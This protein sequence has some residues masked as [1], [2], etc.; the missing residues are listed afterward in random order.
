MPSRTRFLLSTLIAYATAAGLAGCGAPGGAPV[1]AADMLGARHRADLRA[2]EAEKA[3]IQRSVERGQAYDV[4]DHGRLYV[5]DI[6][7]IGWP[8][9]AFLRVEYTYENTAADAQA[10]PIVT[11]VLADPETGEESWVQDE[12]R[13]PLGLRLQPGSTY[14]SWIEAPTLGLHERA[15]WTWELRV[16]QGSF[17]FSGDS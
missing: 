9:A 6:E 8:T 5:R 10:A 12:G 4:G 3:R 2:F 16:E 11:L 7:L 13:L 15:G 1:H 14:S 17:L